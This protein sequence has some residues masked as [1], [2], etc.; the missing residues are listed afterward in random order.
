MIGRIYR[1]AWLVP[2]LLLNAQADVPGKGFSPLF[3]GKDLS[4]WWG[5]RTANPVV[6]MA[7]TEQRKEARRLASFENINKH[8]RAES[9]VLVNDGKG[10]TLATVK[11]YADFE[12]VLEYKTE[13]RADSG[14]YLRGIP[15]V[16]IWDYTDQAKFKLGADKGSGG[17]WNNKASREGKDPLVLADK[18]FGEWNAM[19]ILMVGERVTVELNGQLVVDHA[20]LENY[21][22]R[23][24]P[25]PPTGPIQL[26][27]HGG[28][29]AWR[30][31]FIREIGGA[32]A[33][34]ILAANCW[35]GGGAP[36]NWK[37]KV[38]SYEF[39]AG[40]IRCKDKKGGTVFTENEYADFSVRFEF[41][42]PPGGNNG[43]ALR[44]PG[45]GNP[46]YAGMCELQ[47]LDNTSPK[48]T[49]LDSRQ[50][51]GSAYGM[52]PAHR[53]YLRAPG[54]WNFQTVDVAGSTIQVELNGTRILD[55]DLSVVS[56]YMGNKQH[57]GK[58]L[59]SGHF[60]FAGHGSA[61]AFRNI[62][63]KELAHE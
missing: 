7:E 49:E 37:G 38:E 32:E 43:L 16:Q 51:H 36:G 62:L 28:E 27:T 52:V 8:W 17:L 63:I 19:R 5:L 9:G 25:I 22:D 53:G 12:L 15:Q 11:N 10:L 42:V 24:K 60:G 39:N 33:N 30:N 45:K 21:F 61:V 13:A 4:G 55:A 35:N 1:I 44:Y 6:W 46:A 29:I 34:R 26:Q 56:E 20:R 50:Y 3:N 18:P 47:V 57:P 48:Y 2:A 59:T 40:T 23:N 14:V 54:E 58:E 41:K 31:I